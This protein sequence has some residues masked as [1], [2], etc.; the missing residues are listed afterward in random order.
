MVDELH[1]RFLPNKIVL[2]ADAAEGQEFLSRHVPFFENLK[3]V[4]G[5]QTAYICEDYSCQLPTS[6]IES[7]MQILET[8]NQKKVLV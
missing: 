4:G 2:F 6:D 8:I 1:S 5:K 7:M 3:S